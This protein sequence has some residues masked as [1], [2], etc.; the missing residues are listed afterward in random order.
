L[1][2]ALVWSHAWLAPDMGEMGKL[3]RMSFIISVRAG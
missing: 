2:V 1:F 3:H